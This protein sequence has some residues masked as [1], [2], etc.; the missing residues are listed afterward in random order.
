MPTLPQCFLSLSLAREM[1]IHSPSACEIYPTL[2]DGS[3]VRLNWKNI[4]IKSDMN[5]YGS[6]LKNFSVCTDLRINCTKF[7]HI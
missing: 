3:S 7:C 4:Y 6:S 5:V 2:L 1:I